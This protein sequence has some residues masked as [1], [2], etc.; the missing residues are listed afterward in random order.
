M[1]I[2]V[3]LKQLERLER[4]YSHAPERANNIVNNALREVEPLL[5][6][7]AVINASGR[8]GPNIV[9]GEY[10][11]KFRT[12]IS[13]NTLTLSNPSEQAHRLE[14]GFYGADSLGRVY[15]QPPFPHFRPAIKTAGVALKKAL[16]KF[17]KKEWS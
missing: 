12:E 17:A 14:Y 5:M 10:V 2:E 11:S 4:K 3:N 9:T 8:P 7:E 6:Q 13:D 15:N 16:G 1:K